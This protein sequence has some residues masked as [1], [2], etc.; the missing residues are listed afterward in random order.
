MIIIGA[1][2]YLLM[3][4]SLNLEGQIKEANLMF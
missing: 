3:E 4:N 1:K 2:F